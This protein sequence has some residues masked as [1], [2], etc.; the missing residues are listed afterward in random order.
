MIGI[1]IQIWIDTK[2]ES[3]IRILIG[4]KTMPIHSTGNIEP[5]DLY[6]AGWQRVP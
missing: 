4:V 5:D 2:M 6:L 3:W 1:R